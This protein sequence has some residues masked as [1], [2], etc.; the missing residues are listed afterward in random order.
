MSACSRTFDLAEPVEDK[1]KELGFDAVA[2][3]GH[4]DFDMGVYALQHHLH[5]PTL[6]RELD[7]V[8]QEVPNN[9][10]QPF[11][12]A[13]YRTGTRIQNGLDPNTP[14]FGGERQR[15]YGCIDDRGRLY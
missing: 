4:A 3:I 1:S 12:I 15:F 2:V 13:R 11:E 8:R 10:L 5:P 14:R 7:R 6:L 9:L